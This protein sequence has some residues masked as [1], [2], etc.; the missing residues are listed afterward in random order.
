MT[1]KSWALLPLFLLLFGVFASSASGQTVYTQTTLSCG[2]TGC[3]NAQ[4]TPTA[5]LSYGENLRYYGGK[6]TGA[7]IWNGSEYTDFAGQL[8]WAGYGNHYPLGTWLLQGTFD[9]GL[10]TV[11]ETFFC[12]RSCGIRSNVAG[13]VVG[14]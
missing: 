14:P 4:F 1:R 2:L 12:F 9:N 6:F 3:T 11:T 8:N 7:V 13:T 10:Y 5:T